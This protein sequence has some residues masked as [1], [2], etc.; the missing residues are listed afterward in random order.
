MPPPPPSFLAPVGGPRKRPR[1][2]AQEDAASLPTSSASLGAF[3]SFPRIVRPLSCRDVASVDLSVAWVAS[4]PMEE[5]GSGDLCERL[6]WLNSLTCS[7]CI[8]FFVFPLFSLSTCAVDAPVLD[9]CSA[10]VSFDIFSSPPGSGSNHRFCGGSSMG[11]LFFFSLSCAPPP[12]LFFSVS[13]FLW[14]PTQVLKKRCAWRRV[15]WRKI[16]RGLYPMEEILLTMRRKGH[17]AVR[18]KT[19]N[20]CPP[21][22][23]CPEINHT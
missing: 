19:H 6:R 21:H 18:P 2:A 16:L 22:T 23:H 13:P 11:F 10:A 20:L 9:V 7:S 1:D 8:C 15:S 17:A 12:P 5:W 14:F 4:L 3:L